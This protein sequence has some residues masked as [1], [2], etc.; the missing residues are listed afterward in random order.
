MVF[1]PVSLNI[2]WV[3]LAL[4]AITHEHRDLRQILVDMPY[5]LNCIRVHQNVRETLGEEIVEQCLDLDHLLVYLWESLS[6]RA[7]VRWTGEMQEGTLGDHIVC[8]LPE[9]T[10]RWMVIVNPGI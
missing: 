9:M 8:L 7:N 2:G 4:Q 10:R 6:I 5:H 1:L 3:I